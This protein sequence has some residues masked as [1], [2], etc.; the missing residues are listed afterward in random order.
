M[1][2]FS[3]FEEINAWE[4][5][6]ELTKAIYAVRNQGLFNKD[7]GLREQ[8]RRASVS[9]MANIAE[10]FDR[11]GKKEFIQFL[12]I[13]RGSLGEIKSHLYVALDMNYI[14]QQT[15]DSLY[16]AADDINCMVFR[17]MAYLQ[18]STI[19]GLKYK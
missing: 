14:D 18:K 10:G 4:K 16:K 19:K 13:S 2:T 9:V 3:R 17:L 15:F 5:A 6:R 11:G 8:I 1:A 12:S 7:I